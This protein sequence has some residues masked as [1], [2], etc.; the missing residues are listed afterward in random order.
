MSKVK[1]PFHCIETGK[2]Y[3]KGQEYKGKRKDIAHVMEGFKEEVKE[4]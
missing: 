4:D 1:T 2:T 3:K